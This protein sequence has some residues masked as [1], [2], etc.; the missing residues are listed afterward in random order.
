MKKAAIAC[1]FGFCFNFLLNASDN[2]DL[3]DKELSLL[4]T[5]LHDLQ[6]K[7][8]QEEIYSQHLMFEE[9]KEYA[10]HM[11]QVEVYADK[12]HQIEQQIERLKDKKNQLLQSSDP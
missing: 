7:A 11:K 4:Q 6:I 9:W 8:M 2:I 5:K 3:I 1:F 12:A 10:V